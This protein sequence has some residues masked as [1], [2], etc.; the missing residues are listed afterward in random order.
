MSFNWTWQGCDCSSAI[1][2]EAGTYLGSLYAAFQLL[3]I[4]LAHI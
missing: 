1:A 3:K 2:V 4:L